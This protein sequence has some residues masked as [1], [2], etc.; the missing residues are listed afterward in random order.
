MNS[1]HTVH[2]ITIYLFRPP[3]FYVTFSYILNFTI[4]TLIKFNELF[5]LTQY[6]HVNSIEDMTVLHKKKKKMIIL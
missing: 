3:S 5:I 1:N 4:L 2:N 6:L